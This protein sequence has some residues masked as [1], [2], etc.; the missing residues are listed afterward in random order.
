V[1]TDRSHVRPAGTVI[2]GMSAHQSTAWLPDT[3]ADASAPNA[4][5]ADG[6]VRHGFG[7]DR[8][9]GTCRTP[10]VRR[11]AGG[12]VYVHRYNDQRT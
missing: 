1:D 12:P 8:R 7:P 6:R 3:T 9:C 5:I 4:A 11:A 10:A 2:V